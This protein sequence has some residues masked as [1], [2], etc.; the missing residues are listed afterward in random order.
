MTADLIATVRQVIACP[1]QAHVEAVN[2]RHNHVQK[3][4]HFGEDVPVPRKG[5]VSAGRG[6][7]GIIPGSMGSASTSCAAWATPRV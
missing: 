6:E 4:H 3:L 2:C 7:M 5:A 1:F